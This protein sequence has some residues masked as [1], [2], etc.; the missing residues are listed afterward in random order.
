MQ[1]LFL[2]ALTVSTVL[3]VSMAEPAPIIPPW[4]GPYTATLD[5]RATTHSSTFQTIISTV[6]PS[7][8]NEN[9]DQ[10]HHSNHLVA[11]AV[12]A[13]PDL[14]RADEFYHH[15]RL[16]SALH[17]PKVEKR[18]EELH[19]PYDTITATPGADKTA[20]KFIPPYHT[21]PTGPLLRRRKQQAAQL[22]IPQTSSSTAVHPSVTRIKTSSDDTTPE[23]EGVLA[24]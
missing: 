5:K 12:S 22:Q 1:F 13:I 3:S 7:K 15:H 16:H 18:A 6:L 23:I 14:K 10:L 2:I 24:K 20:N 9:A 17:P 11:T 4:H 21:L 8:I 19:I